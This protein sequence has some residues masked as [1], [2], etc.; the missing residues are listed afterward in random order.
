MNCCPINVWCRVS[1]LTLKHRPTGRTL[2]WPSTDTCSSRHLGV[3]SDLWVWRGRAS[4]RAAFF[5]VSN[6]RI[7]SLNEALPHHRVVRGKCLN[8]QTPR[9][10]PLRCVFQAPKRARKALEWAHRGPNEVR[11]TRKSH[12]RVSSSQALGQGR[13]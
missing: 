7:G 6:E 8:G 5:I 1:V 10:G 2:A 3:T 9:F 13:S 11:Y 4:R 12:L